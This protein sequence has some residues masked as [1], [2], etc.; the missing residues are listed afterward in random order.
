MALY[1]N[2]HSTQILF[3]NVQTISCP[4]ALEG[5]LFVCIPWLALF[6]LNSANTFMYNL[7][8]SQC[9]QD[10]WAI[11]WW[12]PTTLEAQLQIL[13]DKIGS[14]IWKPQGKS[15]RGIHT[16]WAVKWQAIHT[17]FVISLIPCLRAAK[18]CFGR[19]HVNDSDFRLALHANLMPSSCV[20]CPLN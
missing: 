3:Y 9:I 12:W 16:F 8:L 20:P 15:H 11:Q 1:S 10:F 14:G 2:T 19:W 18:S 7:Q 4:S 5:L 6:S 17:Q 13:P